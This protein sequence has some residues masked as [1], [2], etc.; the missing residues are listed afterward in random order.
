MNSD[1]EILSDARKGDQNA[2]KILFEKYYRT[3]VK[4]AALITGSMDIAEDILQETFVRLLNRKIKHKKGSLKSYLTTIA[5]R[6]A[7]KEK[8][9]LGRYLRSEGKEYIDNTNS[10]LESRIMEENQ[11]YI[12]ETITSLP[13][14]QKV[15]L[16]LRFYNELSY[17]DIADILQL[18]VGTVKSRIYYAVKA[19][20]GK[21]IER[22]VIE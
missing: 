5:F 15:V 14:H 2:S 6:L 22:R 11:N 9:R 13:E 20:R 12:F 10:P 21:L 8:K 16:V 18:P 3:I 4:M 1:W 17:E 19:C 7:L